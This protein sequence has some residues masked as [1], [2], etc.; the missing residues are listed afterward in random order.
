LSKQARFAAGSLEVVTDRFDIVVANILLEPI[1]TMLKP[2]HTAIVPGGAV[3]LS[4]ILSAELPQLRGGL[5]AH[6]WR[7]TQQASQE[8]WTAVICEEA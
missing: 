6:G 2:L 1:L 4:G 3:V 5:S 7:I 8:E